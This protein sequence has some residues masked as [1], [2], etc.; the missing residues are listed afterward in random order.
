MTIIYDSN[1]ESIND[2]A[3]F[4]NIL[5]Q[6]NTIDKPDYNDYGPSFC[7]NKQYDQRILMNRLNE[8]KE[9]FGFIPEHFMHSAKHLI[10][11]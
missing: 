2:L 11:K 1:P 6:Y 10:D 5:N 8:F 7:L 3:I 4:C 9:Q